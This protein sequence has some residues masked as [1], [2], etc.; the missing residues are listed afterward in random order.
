MSDLLSELRNSIEH[1][2]EAFGPLVFEDPAAVPRN[3][4]D[5]VPPETEEAATDVV[6]LATAGTPAEVGPPETKG[7]STSEEDSGPGASAAGETRTRDR[8]L[9]DE[10]APGHTAIKEPGRDPGGSE[11]AAA[12][13]LF[14]TESAGKPATALRSPYERIASLIPHSS[15]LRGF[16]SLREVRSFVESTVLI[17]LDETRLNPVFGVGNPEADLMVIGEAPGADEDRQGEPFVGRAGQLLTRILQAIGFE[18]EDVYIAN[19][20][21]SRPPNN[22]DP[23]P[24]EVSAHIP[25]LYKQIALIKPRVLLCVG[26]TAGTSLLD[27]KTSLAALRGTF[28]DYHGLP[29]MVTY[30]PAALLRNPHW[31]RPTWEDVQLLRRRY[32]ELGGA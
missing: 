7:A 29:V 8:T 16:E 9:Q 24:G 1:Q 20:L 3:A 17:P 13:G 32:D 23:L 6:P 25:I 2:I 18:R 5:V 22:R 10:T 14:G 30:H 28:H 11:E 21:K 4:T 31:K 19:I 12:S 27:R 15:P 26:K